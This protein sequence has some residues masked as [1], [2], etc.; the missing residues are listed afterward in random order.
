MLDHIRRILIEFKPSLLF[1]GKFLLV[2]VAG[3]L[4]YGFFVEIYANEADALTWFVSEQTTAI[5]RVWGFDATTVA[6]DTQPKVVLLNGAETVVNVY[7]GCNGVN[8]MIIFVSFLVA[9]ST[10][11]KSM[12]AFSI[13]G[14]VTIHI[15]NLIRIVLLYLVAQF[16]PDYMY[17]THKYLFTASIYVIVFILWVMWVRKFVNI[18]KKTKTQ[19]S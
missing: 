8:I 14:M 11:S 1:V 17:F 12:L 19:G 4:A 5:L 16:Q 9:V 7:E 6:H 3:S 2:Y 10:P 15:F 13:V 18:S